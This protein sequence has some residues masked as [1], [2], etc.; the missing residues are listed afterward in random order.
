[1]DRIIGMFSK[2]AYWNKAKFRLRDRAVITAEPE[3]AVRERNAI[4]EE[5]RRDFKEERKETLKD[6]LWAEFGQRLTQA[7][8]DGMGLEQ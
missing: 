3:N 2:Q 4:M 5:A 1:M 8:T 7:I 6:L